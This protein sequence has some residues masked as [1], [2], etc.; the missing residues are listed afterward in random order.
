MKRFVLLFAVLALAALPLAAQNLGR[1]SVQNTLW[2]GFG[3]PDVKD[4]GSATDDNF[5]F[6]GITDTV[7]ARVDVGKFTMDGMLS[8]SAFPNLYGSP[9][10]SFSVSNGYDFPTD[11][12]TQ[13]LFLGEKRS[14]AP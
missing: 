11:A 12:L 1:Q 10:D 7:Q 2:S 14:A 5:T 8:W 4:D 9:C 3:L 13:F 6:A